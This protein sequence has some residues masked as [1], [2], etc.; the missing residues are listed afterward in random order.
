MEG[1]FAYPVSKLLDTFFLDVDEYTPAHLYEAG[2][3]YSIDE[4]EFR[5]R[6]QTVLLRLEA[7]KSQQ[8]L[9]RGLSLSRHEE[10]A[11]G[12]DLIAHDN[13]LF[14]LKVHDFQGARAY[15][16]LGAA[17]RLLRADYRQCA[18][19]G[20]YRE[21]NIDDFSVLQANALRRVSAPAYVEELYHWPDGGPDHSRV[22]IEL[23]SP[24]QWALGTDLLHLYWQEYQCASLEWWPDD[25][26]VFDGHHEWCWRASWEQGVA[27]G[28]SFIFK[29]SEPDVVWLAADALR[30]CEPEIL[31]AR[32]VAEMG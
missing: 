24:D 14:S 6:A 20:M 11:H 13:G 27:H 18:I 10:V 2:D 30:T 17:T 16:V 19:L 31:L 32:L 12:L 4:A 28:A 1:R 29:G 25:I 7:M 23:S 8:R 15:Q 3:P 22:G 21:G 5:K 26:Q 9:Q